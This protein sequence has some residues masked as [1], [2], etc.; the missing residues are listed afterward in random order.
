MKICV[1]QTRPLQG[2]ISANIE[3]HKKIIGRATVNAADLIIFPEL[4]LTGYEP[5]LAKELATNQG[6]TRL[7]CFQTISDAKQIAIGVGMPT[8]T[9]TFPRISM[10]LFQPQ[11][12]RQTHSKRYLHADEEEFFCR[13]ES[14]PNIIDEK[15]N[16]A[17]AIC[18]ELSV[19][20]H[21][22]SAFRDGARTYIAS[23]A[24]DA[25][26]V[27]NASMRLSGIA[28]KYSMT[29]LMSNGLGPTSGFE[30][31]GNTS[32]WNNQGFLAGQLNDTEEG[33]LTIDTETQRIIKDS[34][35]F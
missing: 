14:E 31:A 34:V 19:P 33:V 1:A 18:Y 3:N 13:G 16:I 23:V 20:E 26:G 32:I 8:H 6:D 15:N 11:Q 5:D 22:E 17:L 9:D 21:A 10:I 27:K 4:S 30:C 29:V 12:K 35:F 2:D 28:K 7:D 25:D 24:K